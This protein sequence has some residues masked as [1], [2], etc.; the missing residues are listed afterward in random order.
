MLE[1]LCCDFG[2]KGI[3]VKILIYRW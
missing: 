3:Q 2:K 1:L